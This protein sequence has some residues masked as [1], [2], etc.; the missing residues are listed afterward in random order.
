MKKNTHNQFL[1]GSWLSFYPF[2]TDSYEYQLD[3]MREAGLNFNIFPTIGFGGGM[4]SPEVC[5]DVEKQYAARD[6]FYL[7]RGGMDE[8][9][10][11]TAVENARDKD[12]CIG[13]YLKDEPGGNAL[14]RVGQHVRAYREADTERY[15]FVNLFPS[16]AGEAVL[17]GSYYEY[18]S[19]YVREAGAENIEYLSHDF[20]PFFETF[21]NR[22]IFTDLEVVRRVALENQRL[23]T[24]AFPQSSAWNGMRMP[25]ID[26]MRWNIYAYLAYGFK[27]LSWFNL[28]CPGNT[29]T[30]GEGF[31]DSIIYRDGTI[32]NKSLFKDFSKLNAEI[33]NL[34]DTLMKLDT[35]HAYHTVDQTAGV[36]L[37]PPDWMITPVGDG[38]LII[39][40]MVTPTG[41]ET[42]VMIFNKDW[43][44]PLTTSFRISQFSGIESLTYISPFNGNAYPVFAEDG[45]FTDTFRPGEGKLYKLNGKLSYRVLPLDCEHTRL[46]VD[47]PVA[48]ELI[49]LDMV[50]PFHEKDTSVA[51][52]ICTN[53]RF[54][55]DK[56]TIHLFDGFPE[57]GKLR[58]APTVGKYIR[59]A[60]GG[61]GEDPAYGYAELRIRFA[62]E[63]AERADTHKLPVAVREPAPLA[64]PRG[65]GI[66]EVEALL[67]KTVAVVYANR[68]STEVSVIWKLNELDTTV[69]GAGLLC[70]TILLPDGTPTPEN[71]V[72]HQPITVTYDVDY[73]SLDEA[74]A[75][76]DELVEAEYTPDSWKAVKEYYDAAVAMKDGTYPQNAVTVAYWQLLDRVR[77]LEPIQWSLPQPE[78]NTT[79]DA[80][81]LHVARGI[82]PATVATLA[83]AV[84]GALAGVFASKQNKSRKKK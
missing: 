29:D 69:S 30:E 57:D 24:H 31:R 17:E 76:V 26:E 77:E 11:Q 53:K 82:L 43:K 70:G 35:I 7:M 37:L 19:R 80:H 62:A 52:Q 44:K 3:Q 79:M 42:F 23:R 75:V 45:V 25:N 74:L 14:P 16:Y 58:F 41:D 84:A 47:L 15:P 22:A 72:A 59:I 32:R 64:I 40:H 66:R 28:V 73:T 8:G 63:P 48:S 21:T 65:A 9:S 34:G 12:H 2:E 51:L 55:E 49:G 18:C 39:S 27:A 54:T 10:M 68:T 6:M 13:Y 61:E 33:H 36:E 46:D 5:A 50:C 60:C 56:T 1:I 4:E 20:Y 78:Q 71:L 67:P 38:D 81:R 83:G